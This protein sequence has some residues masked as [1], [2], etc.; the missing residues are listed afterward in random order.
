MFTGIIE[1]TGAIKRVERSGGGIVL[2]VQA[3]V[4]LEGLRAGDSIATDGVCLTVTSFDDSSFRADVMPETARASAL[5]HARPGDAVNLER[6]LPVGGRLGGHLVSGHV[7]G[8]GRV[9]AKLREANA[10]WLTITAGAEI[11][12]YV[13]KRGSIAIDGVSLTV[14]SVEGDSFRVSIIPRTGV[15]TTLTRKERGA[16]V[17]VETDLVARYVER[18]AA[19]PPSLPGGLTLDYLKENGF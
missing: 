14:A 2:E 1:E 16:L 9:A 13:I 19:L 8:T 10:T 7:D 11:L 17:N 6:A 5:G 18:L 12:R 3:R 4:V 15:E